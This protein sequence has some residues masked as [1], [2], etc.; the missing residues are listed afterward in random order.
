MTSNEFQT[1]P[2]LNDASQMELDTPR[3]HVPD[4]TVETDYEIQQLQN[5]TPPDVQQLNGI[6]TRTTTRQ[7]TYDVDPLLYAHHSSVL[8]EKRTHWSAI[9]VTSVC[10]VLLTATL[11][12]I[13]YLR[14][15]NPLCIVSK[16]NTVPQATKCTPE[17]I[18]L[19][20]EDLG[21]RVTFLIHFMQ[22]TGQRDLL[23]QFPQRELGRI[24]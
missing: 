1:F 5:V 6:H 13:I 12:F 2:Q 7:Q 21:P 17:N 8:Q 10:A 3:L 4:I 15:C 11:S 23:S 22:S 14:S 9:T 16:P 18:E 19:R 20:T 24:C